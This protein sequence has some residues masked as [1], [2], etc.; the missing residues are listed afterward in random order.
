MAYFPKTAHWK[1]LVPNAES[2]DNKSSTYFKIHAPPQL[3]KT[4]QIIY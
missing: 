1:P 2:N 3:W 4:N